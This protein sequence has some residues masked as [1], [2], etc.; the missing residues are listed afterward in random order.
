MATDMFAPGKGF[1]Y[2]YG[3][4]DIYRKAAFKPVQVWTA[5]KGWVDDPT[6]DVAHDLHSVAPDAIEGLAKRILGEVPSGFLDKP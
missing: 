6:A 3:V 4:G 2:Y 5:K 1:S